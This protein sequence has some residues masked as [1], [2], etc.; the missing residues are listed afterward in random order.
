MATYD[1]S[2]TSGLLAALKSA[3][4]GDVIDLDPGTYSNVNIQNVKIAGEVTIT[5]ADPSN[6]AVLADL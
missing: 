1:V 2:S 4:S 5:S 3:Q 6:Q